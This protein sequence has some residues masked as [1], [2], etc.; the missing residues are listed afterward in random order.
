M[1]DVTFTRN[2]S[3]ASADDRDYT[4]VR[5]WQ[6]PWR[7]MKKPT[8]I[9][10]P[11]GTGGRP[12]RNLKPNTTKMVLIIGLLIPELF[13]TKMLCWN[14]VDSR[15]RSTGRCRIAQRFQ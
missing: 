13:L 6:T 3:Y 15:R 14:V 8:F 5:L 2:A 4:N 12:V 1:V 9:L 11:L 10:P 7:P